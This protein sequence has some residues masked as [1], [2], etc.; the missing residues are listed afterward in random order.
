MKIKNIAP[1]LL[2]PPLSD[3][4]FYTPFPVGV[5]K[6]LLKIEPFFL[7]QAEAVFALPRIFQVLASLDFFLL[8]VLFFQHRASLFFGTLWQK[9]SFGLLAAPESRK[10]PL[11][12]LSIALH[13]H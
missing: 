2:K 7:A 10:A 4:V 13:K 11:L 12:F 9:K 3:F 8:Q 1:L 5:E 6:F